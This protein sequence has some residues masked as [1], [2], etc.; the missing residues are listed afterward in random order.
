[1]TKITPNK[2]VTLTSGH[3]V[4]HFSSDLSYLYNNYMQREEKTNHNHPKI[5]FNHLFFSSSQTLCFAL[6]FVVSTWTLQFLT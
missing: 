3:P 5:A 4:D 1:M 6:P 2:V